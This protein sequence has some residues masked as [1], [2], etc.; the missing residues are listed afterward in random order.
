MVRS[1]FRGNTNVD[2]CNQNVITKNSKNYT[3][4]FFGGGGVLLT[5]FNFRKF[6]KREGCFPFIPRG[7]VYAVKFFICL[8]FFKFHTRIF[9]HDTAAFT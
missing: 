3:T 5:Q 8:F 4:F 9:F 1:H 6:N 2:E 7:F